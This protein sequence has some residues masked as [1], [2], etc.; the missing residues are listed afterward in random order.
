[1]LFRGFCHDDYINEIRVYVWGSH[2]GL[3]HLSIHFWTVAGALV[4]PQ[5]I[6]VHWYIPRKIIEKAVISLSFLLKG[7]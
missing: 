2:F 4:N 3:I 6:R 1:M 7:I 5:G